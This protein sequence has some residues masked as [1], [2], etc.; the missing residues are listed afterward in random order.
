MHQITY[1]QEIVKE[2]EEGLVKYAHLGAKYTNAINQAIDYWKS[3]IKN[4]SD[5]QEERKAGSYVIVFARNHKTNDEITNIG[6]MV[7]DEEGKLVFRRMGPFDRAIYRGDLNPS[8]I[9]YLD[10]Y[11]ENY[12]LEIV[13]Q[14]LESDGHYMS[15]IQMSQPRKLIL[16]EE[17]YESTYQSFVLG[18]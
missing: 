12:T 1:I 17:N 9:E 7:F 11:G 10:K 13:K 6:I 8:Y 18:L 4:R 3:V 16:H 14:A 5:V 2:C 15:S